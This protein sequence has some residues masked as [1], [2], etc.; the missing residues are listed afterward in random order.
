MEPNYLEDRREMKQKI[1][2]LSYIFHGLAGSLRSIYV[3]TLPLKMFEP[4]KTITWLRSLK[5]LSDSSVPWKYSPRWGASVLHFQPTF[6]L[7]LIDMILSYCLFWI[8]FRFPCRHDIQ[9]GIRADSLGEIV[10]L[11]TGRCLLSIS[12]VIRCKACII[13]KVSEKMVLISDIRYR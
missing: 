3:T 8:G 9:L 2:L 12:R 10:Y 5:Y 4:Q 13:Q 7:L 6:R 11:L 1:S